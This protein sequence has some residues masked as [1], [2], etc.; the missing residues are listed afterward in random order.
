VSEELKWFANATEELESYRGKHIA[1]I[2][3]KVVASGNN[4]IKV[5]EKAKKEHPNKNPVLAFIPKYEI[6]IFQNYI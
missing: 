3:N 4:A 6:N 2:K 5:W 1:I